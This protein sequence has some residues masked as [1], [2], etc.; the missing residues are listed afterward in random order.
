M[1]SNKGRVLQSNTNID[2]SIST[3]NTINVTLSNVKAN[4]FIVVN[5]GWFYG[6]DVTV[7]DGTSY[8]T[9]VDTRSAN[10]NS[11]WNKIFYLPFVSAGTH[12]ITATRLA[13]TGTLRI[14]ALEIAG[15]DQ[16]CLATDR[17]QDAPGT[18]TD[19]FTSGNTSSISTGKGYFLLGLSQATN[20]FN[21]GDPISAGTGFTLIPDN[22]ILAAEFKN[23][24]SIGPQTATFTHSNASTDRITAILVFSTS[25]S[26]EINA[27]NIYVDGSFE[28]REFYQG[29]LSTNFLFGQMGTDWN[30]VDNIPQQDA[31]DAFYLASGYTAVDTGTATTAKIIQSANFDN[32]NSEKYFKIIAYDGSNN[33][34]L[35]ETANTYITKHSTLISAKF[36]TPFNVTKGQVIKL[37]VTTPAAPSGYIVLYKNSGS[38]TSV[39]SLFRPANFNYTSPPSTLGTPD[40]PTNGAEF[41]VWVE[42]KI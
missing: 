31:G 37:V 27:P 14:R 11:T 20:E 21:V 2:D 34:K 3:S 32:Y 5:V 22:S 30:K 9:A 13:S 25:R 26:T 41:I 42:G 33:S 35:G 23:T 10:N 18:G 6:D 4:S 24:Y 29:R 16:L 28:S 17:L 19:A 7:S 12:T 39:L 1:Q 8:I 15:V 40:N 38:S 36:I